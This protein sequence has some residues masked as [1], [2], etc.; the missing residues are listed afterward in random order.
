LGLLVCKEDDAGK[1][2]SLKWGVFSLLVLAS[3]LSGALVGLALVY[4]VDL[5]QIHNLEQYRPIAN[6]ELYD[7]QGRIIG[8]FALQRR[9]I[10]RYEDYP[11]ILYDA[12]I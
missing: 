11:P 7:D 12:V 4:T 3:A 10:A 9:V 8:S 1:R 6:T 5:P 2:K